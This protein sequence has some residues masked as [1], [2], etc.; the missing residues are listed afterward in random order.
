[1]KKEILY[2]TLLNPKDKSGLFHA[3]LN[4]I[5]NNKYLYSVLYKENIFIQLLKKLLNRPTYFKG[6]S[7][8]FAGKNIK[9]QFVKRSL[10]SKI[11]N[12]Y[13][14][15]KVCNTLT[16]IILNENIELIHAHWGYPQGY[17]A[18]KLSEKLNIPYVVTYHGS[19]IHTI[20]NNNKSIKNIMRVVLDHAK[21]NIFVSNNLNEQALKLGYN[22]FQSRIIPNGINTEIFNLNRNEDGFFTIIF[23]GSLT[24]IKN[25]D[26]LPAIFNEINKHLL[27]TKVKYCI[28]GDGPLRKKIEKDLSQF[29]ISATFLGHI[30]QVELARQLNKSNVLL[31]PSKKEGWPCVILEANSCGVVA[32]GTNAGGIPEAINNA[33]LVVQESK[34]F[35]KDIAKVIR[36]IK[37]DDYDKNKISMNAKA[38]SWELIRKKINNL[39]NEIW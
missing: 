1:M 9:F 30:D 24:K 10:F 4:R 27:D 22:G 35:E 2:I 17:I 34:N 19:D 26:K 13:D 6:D 21:L 29:R 23:V 28:A 8:S 31:L 15:D 32:I 18:Y 14:V 7:Y 12:K 5:D 20:P 25:A 3:T 16:D 36:Q 11:A 37:N 39:Y 33:K 38:Y